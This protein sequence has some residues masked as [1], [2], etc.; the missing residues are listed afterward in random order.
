MALSSPP[1][2]RTATCAVPDLPITKSPI[3]C[4]ARRCRAR[5]PSASEAIVDPWPSAREGPEACEC[6]RLSLQPCPS[7]EDRRSRRRP[8]FAARAL[9]LAREKRWHYTPG[10]KFPSFH[11]FGSSAVLGPLA[12]FAQGFAGSHGPNFRLR[13]SVPP[14]PGSPGGWCRMYCRTSDLATGLG[15][16]TGRIFVELESVA[17]TMGNVRPAF[18]D[19]PK[20]K[21]D[22]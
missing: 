19:T 3:F 10:P 16:R 15:P 13:S 20:L 22:L 17:F 8:Y 1:L 14:T 4:P 9:A 18:R 2:N 5:V 12:L 11:P 21:G 7:E 6:F